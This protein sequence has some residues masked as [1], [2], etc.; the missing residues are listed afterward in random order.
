MRGQRSLWKCPK[1]GHRFMTRNMWHACKPSI[2]LRTH[3]RRM[4]SEWRRIFRRF[5]SMVRA[6]GPVT[7][8]HGRVRSCSRPGS[9]WRRAR[10]TTLGRGGFVARATRQA[11]IC[12]PSHVTSGNRVLGKDFDRGLANI[13]VVV[14]KGG[15]APAAATP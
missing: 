13:K 11:P 7:A 14:E 12:G 10:A 6:C 15:A 5:R 8:T 1:C 3:F 9:P 2:A 4:P